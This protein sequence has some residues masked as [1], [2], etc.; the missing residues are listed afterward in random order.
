[1]GGHMKKIENFKE[2]SVNSLANFANKFTYF[3]YV[4]DNRKYP[5]FVDEIKGIVVKAQNPRTFLFC[6]KRMEDDCLMREMQDMLSDFKY[7]Y[8]QLCNTFDYDKKIAKSYLQKSVDYIF[9][10]YNKNNSK[11]MGK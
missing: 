1:M 8:E 3:G 11:E 10:Q 7:K 2:Q 9:L 6:V 5:V 4:N